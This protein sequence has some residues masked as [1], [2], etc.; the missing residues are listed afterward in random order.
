MPYSNKTL[1]LLDKLQLDHPLI[2]APMVGVSNPSMAAA[3][4]SS[5]ALGSLGLGGGSAAAVESALSSFGTLANQPVNLNFLCHARPAADGAKETAWLERLGPLFD[6][7][8]GSAPSNIAAPYGTF[9]DAPETLVALLDGNAAIVSF[10]F[11]LPVAASV[12]AL[13]DSGTCVLASATS[14]TEARWL[15][16]N[17]VD[18][19]IAQGWEAGGHR[20]RFIATPQD[21]QL[22]TL[23]L[24][25]LLAGAV[26]IPVIAAGGINDG[27]SAAAALTLGAAAVQMGTAF[28][29]CPESSAST[30]YRAALAQPDRQT[31]MTSVFSG[32]ESR[33]LENRVTATLGPFAEFAP[34]YPTAYDAGK[35][36]AATAIATGN[37]QQAQDYSAMWA[38]Q[39]FRNNRALPAAELVKRVVTELE[40]FTA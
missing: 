32:R 15:E 22:G 14:I 5:G 2:Q 40:A 20:G 11:G 7:L 33:G 23:A 29:S 4:A 30:A 38:G 6:E 10:H 18:A 9:D 8:G 28:I 19:V 13:R 1:Q 3:V 12:Q 16:A 37:E 31:V 26:D 34:D 25:P 27:T 35:A 17:G 24:V 39:G 21:E 36:L